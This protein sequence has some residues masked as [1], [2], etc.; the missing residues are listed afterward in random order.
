MYNM[1]QLSTKS[2]SRTKR[3]HIHANAAV[4]LSLLLC[5]HHFDNHST[6]I[7]TCIKCL[8]A[9]HGDRNK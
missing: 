8:Y 3:T 4:L 5:H 7:N 1:V 6:F 2:L 9:Y